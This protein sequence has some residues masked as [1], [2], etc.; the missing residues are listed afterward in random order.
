MIQWA[1]S[2]CDT[3]L[4]L[5][6]DLSKLWKRSPKIQQWSSSSSIKH[7]CFLGATSGLSR[8]EREIQT[9]LSVRMGVSRRLPSLRHFVKWIL[10]A[11]RESHP[12]LLNDSQ[13][14]ALMRCQAENVFP[15]SFGSPSLLLSPDFSEQ[16]GKVNT[17]TVGTE[18]EKVTT[19]PTDIT[20]TSQGAFAK[21]HMLIP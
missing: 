8:R 1:C 20:L 5:R 18:L 10:T 17:Q 16:K 21:Q 19:C 12:F 2:S 15:L 4:P 6:S 11:G 7:F 3:P 14:A 13:A 9:E